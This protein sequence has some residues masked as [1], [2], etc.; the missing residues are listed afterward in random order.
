MESRAP[1]TLVLAAGEG[2][3]LRSLTVDRRGNVIPKQFCPLVGENSLLEMAL[4]RAAGVSPLERITTIVAEQHEAWWHGPLTFMPRSNITVQPRNRGTAVGVL[5]PLLSILERDPQARIVMLPS[6]HFV[7]DEAVLNRAVR[8]ALADV[9]RRPERVVL[10]GIVPDESDDEFGW[11]VPASN[12]DG[13][14]SDVAH[15]VEKPA[16]PV[17]MGLMRQGAV[18]NSFILAAKGQTLLELLKN[19]MPQATATVW[20]A[21]A[22]DPCV[23]QKPEALAK[24]YERLETLDFSRDVLEGCV[25]RLSVLPVPHCGWCDLGTP[26]RVARCI[27]QLAPSLPEPA[28]SV[29]TA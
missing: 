3:R 16:A 14:I 17:A 10:L 4:A 23:T 28:L 5:V 26:A 7:A 12:G 11:I 6:D 2:S 15:F 21:I 27:E 8:K 29:A 25:D 19:R 20:E 13:R 24:V 22:Q 1:W 18:W 9:E